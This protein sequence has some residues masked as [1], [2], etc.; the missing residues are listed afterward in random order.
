MNIISKLLILSGI[1][2]IFFGLILSSK[3]SF[4]GKLPG[5]ILI[6][7]ENFT[8]YFPITTLILISLILNLILI[9]LK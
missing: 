3:F 7:K 1:F 4:I 5:D 9:I 6:Q 2:L 8:F